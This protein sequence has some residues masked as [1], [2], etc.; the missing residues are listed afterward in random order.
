MA[1]NRFGAV[2]TTVVSMYPGTAAADYGGQTT[3]EEAIDRAVDRIL[4]A[5]P[6]VVHDQIA[7]PEL[8]LVV[9]RATAG[10]TTATLPLLPGISGTGRIWVGQ[11]SQFQEHP[12][13]FPAKYQDTG[14]LE[15]DPT[16]Y[17]VN[18]T[19]GLVTLNTGM[20]A[21]D[22]LYAT[23]DTDSNSAS[24]VAASL[25]RIAVRGA[26]SELGSRLYSEA[27]QEWLLVDKYEASFKESIEALS[28]GSWI[29][30]ELRFLKWWKEVERATAGGA[31]SIRLPR[32]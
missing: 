30:E 24:F 26:A 25:G 29:P 22:Q 19:T 3:I 31:S 9:Q 27:N 12:Q 5:M 6:Q 28:D 32:G 14:L 2:F 4:A 18:Y 1:F 16:K 10:Q 17:T 11:P 8:I 21:N 7:S 20:V 13:Y 15:L 23:Y